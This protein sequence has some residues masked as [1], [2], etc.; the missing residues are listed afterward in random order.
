MINGRVTK[1]SDSIIDS[2][3][4]KMHR[5][6]NYVTICTCN[7]TEQ[8]A[9]DILMSTHTHTHTAINNDLLLFPI[10]NISP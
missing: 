2:A 4:T 1:M 7:K 9:E 8:K 6:K 3:I 10:S 5:H